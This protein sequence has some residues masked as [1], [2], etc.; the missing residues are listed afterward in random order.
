V[1][2]NQGLLGIA[3]FEATAFIIMLVLFLLFRRDHSVGHFQFWLA[4][5]CC[6]TFSSLCEVAFLIRQ[7]P[8][9]N[10]TLL[11]AQAAALLLFLVWVVQCVTGS[12]RRISSLLPL[13]GLILAGIYYV[14]RRGAQHFAS[15]HWETAILESVI[16]LFAGWLTLRP[17][18]AR[19]GHGAQLL[20]GIFI[21][22]GLHG[23]DRPLWPENPLFLLRVAFDHLL[24]VALGI[25]MV[26]VVLEGAR[27][28]TEE[29]NDKMRRLTLLTAASTQTLSVQ[30]VI[31]PGSEKPC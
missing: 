27:T 21:L 2:E 7:I 10:L 22:S 23:L 28:R 11:A 8:A 14:E 16:C 26:V 20:A 25:S 1:L 6:L 30:E 3:L 29:L 31:R 9:L 17:M 12:D 5:W 19:R 24:D 13:I 18:M 4:G 15:P